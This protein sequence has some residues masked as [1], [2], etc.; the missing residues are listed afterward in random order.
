MVIV[1]L[2]IASWYGPSETYD[3]RF[4]S[5][6]S[7]YEECRAECVGIYLCCDREILRYVMFTSIACC[8]ILTHQYIW[9]R[10]IDCRRH[11]ICKLVE[12]GSSRTRWIGVLYTRNQEMGT[13][14]LLTECLRYDFTFFRLTCKLDM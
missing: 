9:S 4:S 12:H 7:S 3:T 11:H 5:V 14:E 13:S 10:G 2:Q 8:H 1:H 6:A